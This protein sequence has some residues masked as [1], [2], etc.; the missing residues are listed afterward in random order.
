MLIAL[1]VA[2]L[3][4]REYNRLTGAGAPATVP[5][6]APKLAEARR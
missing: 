3:L 1:A 5:G 6:L 2:W 4:L